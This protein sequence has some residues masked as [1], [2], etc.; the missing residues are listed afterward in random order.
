LFQQLV[1]LASH[2]FA[3]CLSCILIHYNLFP[4]TV[5]LL[6]HW[7]LITC[8]P[9]SVDCNVLA[10]GRSWWSWSRWAEVAESEPRSDVIHEG[11]PSLPPSTPHLHNTCDFLLVL[12]TNCAQPFVISETGGSCKCLFPCVPMVEQ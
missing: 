8:R 9:A 10:C 1:K 5:Y 2:H 12:H 3:A 6:V 7:Q 4:V 11:Y